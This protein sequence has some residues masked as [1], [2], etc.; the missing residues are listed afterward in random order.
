VRHVG[1]IASREIRSLFVSPVAYVVLALWAVLAGSFFLTSL[2]GFQAEVMRAQ[3]FQAFDYLRDVNLNDNL[4]LPFLGTMW[5]VLIFAIPGVTMGLFANEKQNGTEELLLTC[6]VTIWEIVLGKFL[7]GGAFV[8]LLTAVVAF[9]PG[10]LFVYGDPEPARTAAGLLGLL[11][12]SLGYVAAGDRRA[13]PGRGPARRRGLAGRPAHLA[14]A[15]LALRAARARA[16]RHPRPR[17]LRV[18]DRNLPAAREVRG[19]VGAMALAR[20]RDGAAR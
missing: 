20:R 3:Q 6:P 13:R 16:R 17:V 1:A 19:G 10:L 9:F 8:L 2:L 5:I 12:V 14:L 18:P 11:L 4:I 15:R 7:A